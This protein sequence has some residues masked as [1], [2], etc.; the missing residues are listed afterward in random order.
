MYN[1]YKRTTNCLPHTFDTMKTYRNIWRNNLFWGHG[2][3]KMIPTGQHGLQKFPMGQRL[4]GDRELPV[5]QI[6]GS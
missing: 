6:G 4:I 3:V 5:G 1:H 2:I